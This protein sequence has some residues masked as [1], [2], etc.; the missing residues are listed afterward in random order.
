MILA[1][2]LAAGQ[3]SGQ[4][5]GE[6][7]P[8]KTW[9]ASI[10][11]PEL[12]QELKAAAIAP[13]GSLIWAVVG[14]RPK[15]QLGGPQT[16]FL[17]ALDSNGKQLRRFDLGPLVLQEEGGRPRV[18]VDGIAASPDGTLYL[19][20]SRPNGTVRW[21]VF[22]ANQPEPK[23]N[24]ILALSRPNLEIQ[25]L[26]RAQDDAFL[27]LGSSTAQALAA[28][29]SASGEVAWEQTF[30]ESGDVFFEG[31]LAPQ[32]SFL[33]AGGR[34][35]GKTIAE[36]SISEVDGAGK[37]I[38]TESFPGSYATVASSAGQYA[39]VYAK[40]GPE[41]Q[42]VWVQG[43]TNQLGLS[44][45]R[46]IFSLPLALRFDI[47]AVTGEGYIVAGVKER[48]LWVSKISQDG[49]PV[50]THT[51]AMAPPDFAMFTSV[52]LLPAQEGFLLACTVLTVQ[53]REQRQS[54]KLI[55]FGAE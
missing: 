20:S 42:E 35:V 47:E 29:I 12:E 23:D 40:S 26:L 36:I 54:V 8:G 53:G 18:N 4:T 25:N 6:P 19:V 11:E 55:R 5:S 39:A 1:A 10:A 45:A 16:L 21:L 32:S 14:A 51:R 22:D 28:K 46:K 24:S 49:T 17:H 31:A 41:G 13:D 27:L 33:L 15:G 37:L 43:L 52:A 44:W 50:W 38:R 2:V 34:S 3:V 7:L 30:D 9:E 48:E